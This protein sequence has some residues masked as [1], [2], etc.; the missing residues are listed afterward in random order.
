M[1]KS[2]IAVFAGYLLMALGVVGLF[3]LVSGGTSMTPT[4][5]AIASLCN[6]AFATAG[7][8]VTA[9]LAND[10]PMIHGLGLMGL[11]SGMWI[12]SAAASGQEPLA[13]QLANLAMT[14]LGILAGSYLRVWQQRPKGQGS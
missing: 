13:F 11:A 8:Y 10:A 14:M 9:L 5:F 3:A 1:V 2:L 4:F 7:G 12:V 6:L